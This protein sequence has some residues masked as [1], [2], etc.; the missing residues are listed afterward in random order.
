MLQAELRIKLA[1]DGYGS[2]VN[3]GNHREGDGSRIEWHAPLSKASSRWPE[4]RLEDSRTHQPH[5][6]VHTCSHTVQVARKD[7][8]T[9][10][11]R[12]AHYLSTRDSVWG[13]DYR[14]SKLVIVLGTIDIGER[15]SVS[16]LSSSTSSSLSSTRTIQYLLLYLPPP[17]SPCPRWS[18]PRHMWACA[19]LGKENN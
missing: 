2:P 10:P 8:G 6:E 14:I 17:P 16:S 18:G 13:H 11:F 1:G 12:D 5:D 19:R 7:G 3:I 4:F 15:L 9:L